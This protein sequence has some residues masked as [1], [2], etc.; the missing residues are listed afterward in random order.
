MLFHLRQRG[1]DAL[2]VCD[3]AAE[4]LVD[5]A[6]AHVGKGDQLATAVTGIG[7]ALNEPARSSRSSRAVIPPDEIIRAS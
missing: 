3:M 1:E 5:H 7:S 6:F 2:L 4:R